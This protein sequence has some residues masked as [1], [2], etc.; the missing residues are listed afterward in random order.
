MCFPAADPLLPLP[1]LPFPPEGAELIDGLELGASDGAMDFEGLMVGIF[2]GSE[3]GDSDGL[4]VGTLET[5]G[6][7]DGIGVAATGTGV[8]SV[9]VVGMVAEGIAGMPPFLVPFPLST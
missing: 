2:E 7:I 4:V 1:P 6:F 3:L 5:E 8:G 9:A